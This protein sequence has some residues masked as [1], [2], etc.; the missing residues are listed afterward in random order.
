MPTRLTLPWG[1]GSKSTQEPIMLRPFFKHYGSKWRL[2]CRAPQP[3]YDTIIEPFAGSAGY[4]LRYGAGRRVL[5]IDASEDTCTIWRYLL[6][7]SEDEILDL[8]V[9]PLHA[10][11][12]YYYF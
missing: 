3:Q 10:G 7:A 6:G 12:L 9:A 2:A 5:L 4:S 8:P 1:P 11:S